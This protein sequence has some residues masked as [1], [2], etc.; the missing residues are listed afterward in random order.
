MPTFSFE[1]FLEKLDVEL[2]EGQREAWK[3]YGEKND[4]RLAC[5]RRWGKSFFGAIVALGELMKD[6]KRIWIVGPNFDTTDKIF[7]Q[8]EKWVGEHFPYMKGFIKKSPHK[9]IETSWGSFLECKS[10]GSD[11]SLIGEQLDLV[12]MDE[13]ARVD[14]KIYH[15]DIMPCL[16]DR[17]GKTIFISTPY[18]KNWFY[19]EFEKAKDRHDAAALRYP[20]YKNPEIPKS[21][22]EKMKEQLPEEIYRQE[23]GAEFLEDGASVFR[24]LER[25]IKPK[26]QIYKDE[27][28]RGH[29]YMMGVDLA[30]HQD[31]TVITVLDIMTHDVVYFERF[32][33]EDFPFQRQKIKSISDKYNGAQVNI[34]ATGLGKSFIDEL[35]RMQ[36][37]IND[38]TFTSRSKKELIE[39]LRIYVEQG[40][41]SIPDEEQLVKEM[42]NYGYETHSKRTGKPLQT[43][44][45]GPMVGDKDDCVDSLALAVWDLA[46]AQIRTEEKEE[47]VPRE[48]T[49]DYSPKPQRGAFNYKS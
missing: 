32:Q 36:I 17:E 2:H 44:K 20:S 3:A 18:G 12:I 10:T 38:F 45:Y 9:K 27:P 1:K 39:K 13:V 19:E 21:F 31:Y 40:G 42:R 43:I 8:V 23:I 41:I 29:A 26:K 22:I 7:R 15:R 33:G 37:P 47:R 6:D 35:A 25:I 24:N 14:P 16:I 34:D 28:D 11:S 48:K 4:L 5:G 46:D 49:F 30:K